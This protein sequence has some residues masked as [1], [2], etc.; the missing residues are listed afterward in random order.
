MRRRPPISTRTDTL[1]PYSTLFRSQA[2]THGTQA[3]ETLHAGH[4]EVQQDEVEVRVA[5]GN[6][7]RLAEVRGLQKITVRFQPFNQVLGSAACDPVIVGVEDLHCLENPEFV[8]SSGAYGCRT[9]LVSGGA[10]SPASILDRTSTRL[11]S[12]N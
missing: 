4:Q 12:S 11:N 2:F 10:H 1:F 7:Q 8:V 3:F 5:G 6:L 9:R